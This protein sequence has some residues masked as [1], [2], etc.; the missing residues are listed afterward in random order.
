LTAPSDRSA[1]LVSFQIPDDFDRRQ[2]EQLYHDRHIKITA[3][4]DYV[5]V[6]P[7][8]FNTPQSSTDF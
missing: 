8:F 6:S 4:N 1:G 2:V 7:H 5:W 3:R